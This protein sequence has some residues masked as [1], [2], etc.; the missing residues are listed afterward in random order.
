MEFLFPLVTTEPPTESATPVIPN[1]GM[2]GNTTRA[3]DRCRVA[4]LY[5]P[6][7]YKTTAIME[8]SQL[9]GLDPREL[10]NTV[11][12]NDSGIMIDSRLANCEYRNGHE[13]FRELSE[14]FPRTFATFEVKTHESWI[15]SLEDY[16]TSPV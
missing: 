12:Q 10:R 3:N 4:E 1:G 5:V 16:G 7:L 9:R 13:E 6:P 2:L 8:D 11:H 14:D 15:S